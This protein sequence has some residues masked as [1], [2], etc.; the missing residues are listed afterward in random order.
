MTTGITSDT[1]VENA[2]LTVAEYKNAPTSID[3]DNLVVNG[4][5]NAQ[6]AELARVIMRASSFINEFLNQSLVAAQIT[7]TQRAR[8][9]GQGWIALHPN[10]NPII[11]LESFQYGATPNILATLTDCSTAWFENQQLI[12]PLNGS[13]LS[14]SSQGPLSFGGASPY[15]QMFCKYT[16]VSGFVN[17]LATGTAL[18]STLTVETGTGI[19]AGQTLTIYDGASTERV[20]VD[21]AYVYASTTVPLTTALVFDHTA[22][23]ISNLPTSV[24]QSCILMTTAFIKM[25]GDGSLTMNITTSPSSNI[26]GEGRYSSEVRMALDMVDKYR[27]IR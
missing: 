19:L 11:A 26:S 12:I 5:A 16:Y 6:D 24:K 17:T 20:T 8:V 2:Y 3:Y 18:A 1:F 23:C 14:Y 10:N 15:L 22:A 4:N 27:R 7:E 21:A 13:D 9:S 25:R